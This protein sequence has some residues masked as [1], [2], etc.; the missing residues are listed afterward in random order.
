MSGRSECF[1][2]FDTSNY[3]TSVAVCD[4]EGRV[5]A[6]LKRPLPVKAG[7]RGLRQSEAVFEHVR[8]LPSL[9]G[10][11]SEVIKDRKPVAVGVSVRPRDAENSYMPCFLAGKSAAYSF[12]AA[13]GLPVYE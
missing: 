9:A 11:L 7:E 4:G 1:I 13:L 12:G 3:T 2:G 10:E 8:N 5:I 6:N